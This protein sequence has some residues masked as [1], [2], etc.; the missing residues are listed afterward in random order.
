MKEFNCKNGGECKDFASCKRCRLYKCLTVGINPQGIC[1]KLNEEQI[2]AFVERMKEH[3]GKSAVLNTAP[4]QKELINLIVMK[5]LLQIEQKVRRIRYSQT[6]IPEFFYTQCDTFESIFSRKLNLIELVNE[7]SIKPIQTVP[8]IFLEKARQ[9]GPFFIRPEPVVMDLLFIFEIGKTFP[10]F[11]RL[12]NNDKIALFSNIAMPLF[13]LC[14]SFYSVQQN[15]DVCVMRMGNKLLRNAVQPFARLKL[16]DEEFLLIRA[17]IYSHMVSPGLSEQA[18]K[19]LFNEAEK[20]SAL[21]MSLVQINY[22]PSPGALRY[23]ELMGLIDG[24]FNTGAK[25]R[26]LLTYISNVLDPN[27]DKVF[28][29]VLAK[30]GTKGPV[31]SHQLFPY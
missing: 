23:V 29:P 14:C 7:F 5:N 31:E 9:F 15:C 18:E 1:T 16:I 21:L 24:L 10:F 22:G 30:I 27:F 2:M 28:P 26:Q 8:A 20:Y 11:D 17:I 3:P 4:E 6:P 13:V 25:Y 12:D 19:L